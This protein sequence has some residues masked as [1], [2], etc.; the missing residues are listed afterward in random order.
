MTLRPT[1]AEPAKKYGSD[2]GD[3]PSLDIRRKPCS[4]WLRQAGL[5]LI[6]FVMLLINQE[7]DLYGSP[8]RVAG[9]SWIEGIADNSP[10]L[11]AEFGSVHRGARNL[12]RSLKGTYLHIGDNAENNRGN[13]KPEGENRDRIGEEEINEPAKRMLFFLWL[14]FVGLTGGLLLAWMRGWGR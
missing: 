5:Y 1:V 10:N 6:S 2:K 7:G 13:D 3:V 11:G 8:L 4:R 14:F 9:F 12:L